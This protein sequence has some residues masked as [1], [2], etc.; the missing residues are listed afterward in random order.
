MAGRVKEDERHERIIRGLLKLPANKRCINCNNL[1]SPSPGFLGLALLNVAVFWGWEPRRDHNMSAQISGPSFVPIAVEH[2]SMAKFTAQE[3]TALQEG[4]NERAREVFFKEWDPQRNGYPDSRNFIKHVFVERRFTGERSTDKPPRGKDDKDEYSENRRSDGNWGGSRSPPNGSY[5]DRRSYSGRSDDRNSRYSYG[6]RSPGYDQNEYKKSPRYFEVVDDRSG[7]TTPVQRFEDRRFSEPRKPDSGSPDFQ[8]EADGSSPVVRP[9]RD[10]LGD[11]APQLRVGE[12]SKPAAEPPKPSVVRP[13]DPPKPIVARPIDPPKPNGTRAIDPPPL[14]KTMSSASSIASS[15]GPLE[16]MKVTNAVSLIDFSADPEPIAPAAPP[17]PASTA[18]QHP[19]NAPAPQ[20]V[21]EQ[22][23]SAPSVSGGDWASFD[24][25]GQQQTPQTSSSANP[26]ESALA[27]LSFSEAPSA[28]NASAF[29]GSIDPTLK[30]ND[31]GHSSTVDQSHNLFDA[32]FGIS[33]NQASAVMSNQGSSVQQSPLAAPTAGLPSQVAANPQGTSGIQG[34]VSSTD[35]K[36]SGRK[37][38]PADIFNALYATSTPMMPG[39]QRAPQF[40]MGYGMQYPAGVFQGMQ[41]YPQAAFPQPTYQQP[42]YPQHV[43]PQP[44]PQPQPVKASNPFDLGNEPAPAQAHMPLS[45]PPGAS[46]GTATQ[47]L[48]GTSSFGVPPQQPPQLYQSAA[49][50]SHFM[51]QQVPNTMPQQPPNSMHAMQQG[52]GSFN[53][54]FDQQAPPRYPQPS[55]PPSYG[56]VGGSN[57]F[58]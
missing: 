20:P 41:A 17:Q 35:S 47:T 30:A 44:Q 5:S 40:G 1:V 16:P 15:E 25:F 26:L 52:L 54:G 13:I 46:A 33:G 24:A 45:G 31:G 18:Q 23:K 42:V 34:A 43:Y 28:H 4:G 12:P 56:S 32:P 2:I 37:E 22:G 11:N 55:T 8:K 36:Y 49:P 9:V 3:V 58:G 39:W 10:I 14:A 53:M 29:P 57:P 21:L 27:Q 48:L 6:D 51:M 19:V 38:L 50:P 7:K